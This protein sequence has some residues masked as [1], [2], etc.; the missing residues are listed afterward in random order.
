MTLVLFVF[1]WKCCRILLMSEKCLQNF[2]SYIVVG[3]AYGASEQMWYNHVNVAN[4]DCSKIVHKGL[5]L[6]YGLGD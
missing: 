1:L 2:F 6:F 5:K 4:L 3:I